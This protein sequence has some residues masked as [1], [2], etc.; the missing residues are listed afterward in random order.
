MLKWCILSDYIQTTENR[1]FRVLWHF[2]ISLES[3]LYVYSE[4]RLHCYDPNTLCP[5]VPMLRL[6]R[7]CSRFDPHKPDTEAPSLCLAPIMDSQRPCDI[8]RQPG[9]KALTGLC[10]LPWTHPKT[11][12]RSCHH[13]WHRRELLP[14]LK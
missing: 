6:G 2:T 12:A 8:F 9:Q 10:N 11:P 4:R 1:K 5:C 3:F 13:W 14:R 7:L